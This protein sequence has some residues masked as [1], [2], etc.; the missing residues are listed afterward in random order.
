M[1]TARELIQSVAKSPLMQKM[2]TD[3][4]IHLFEGG[5]ALH[6]ARLATKS[7]L[8]ICGVFIEPKANVFGLTPFEHMVTSTSDQ[9]ERNTSDDTDICLYG[10]KRWAELACRGNPTAISYI[11]AE[12][13]A[14]TNW[15]WGYAVLGRMKEAI[16]SKKA[17]LHFLGFVNGQMKR[18]LGEKGKGKHGQHPELIENF[19]YDTKTAMHAMRLC[20]E[21]KELMT[22]GFIRYPRPN[23]RE[24]VDIRQGRW[25]LDMVNREVSRGLYELEEAMKKSSLRSKPDYDIVN[26]ELVNAYEE[27]YYHRES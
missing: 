12:N 10:L 21:G 15:L 27:F 1:A 3:H 24:L 13:C 20:G 7:D 26:E 5:S 11:F 14:P 4:L 19:G 25:S 23:V 16:I 2:N 18:L 17:A 9:T 8:D 6:G 22:E